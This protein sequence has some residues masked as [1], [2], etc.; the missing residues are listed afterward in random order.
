MHSFKFLVFVLLMGSSL[1]YGQKKEVKQTGSLDLHLNV[2]YQFPQADIAKLYGNNFNI[3]LGFEKVNF[4]S[5]WF[6]GFEGNYLFA[7]DVKQDV[8][9]NIRT[10]D[11]YILGIDNA[12]A[13]VDLK[14]RGWYAGGYLG[15]LLFRKE[16]PK[17]ISGLRVKMGFGFL[18]HNIRIKDNTGNAA[19]L[20]GPYLAGYD[21]L[22]NGFALNQF[23]GWQVISKDK[24]INFALG[25]E[26]TEGFTKNRR[27]YNFD[28]MMKDESNHF[29]VL[30]GLK[31][32]WVLPVKSIVNSEEYEY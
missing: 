27:V 16:T 25:F 31:L 28:T 30:I 22:T 32:G 9:A 19:Q 1:C 26:L 6:Y 4:L 14:G 3:G 12:V 18:E 24:T 13:N 5:G 8:L 20:V 17:T 23:V 7:S 10:K 2:M 29:D 21:R 11:G 15:N